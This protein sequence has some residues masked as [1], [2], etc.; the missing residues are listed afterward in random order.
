MDWS[1]AEHSFFQ[2]GLIRSNVLFIILVRENTENSVASGIYLKNLRER[3]LPVSGKD[4]VHC[5]GPRRLRNTS[6]GA[7]GSLNFQAAQ[8]MVSL[9]PHASIPPLPPPHPN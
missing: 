7:L 5:C 9:P 3:I 1:L 4:A 2:A 6:W 8:E